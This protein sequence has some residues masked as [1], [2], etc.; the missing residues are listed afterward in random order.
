MQGVESFE[1]IDAQQAKLNNNYRNTK[2]KLLKTNASDK[3]VDLRHYM[4]VDGI[5]RCDWLTFKNRASYI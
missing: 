1:I 3:Y 2:H 5:T 4:H